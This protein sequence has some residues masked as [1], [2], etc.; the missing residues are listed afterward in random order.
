VRRTMANEQIS[1]L[2]CAFNEAAR[3]DAILAAVT[4]HPLI[5]QVIVVDDGSTDGT[6]ER[7]AAYPGVTLISY[8]ENRGKTYALARGVAA[9]RGDFLMLLDADLAGLGAADIEALARPVLSGAADVSLSLR[10]NSLGVYRML[11]LDF[12]SG[13][14]VMPTAL[15]SAVARAMEDLPRWGGEV[16]INQLIIDHALRV[17]V[18]DWPGVKNTR[19]ADKVGPWQGALDEIGMMQSALKVLSPLG[20]V[21]QNLA[22]LKLTRR[23]AA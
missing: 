8:G 9:A 4:T 6:A 10:S 22:L 18:V 1:C 3:I 14:R 12:I 5:G 7:V 15:L 13:E 17:S 16:F 23:A 2:I 20:V 19:K 21:R 11:G